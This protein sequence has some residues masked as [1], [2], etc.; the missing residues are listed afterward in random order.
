MNWWQLIACLLRHKWQTCFCARCGRTR[1]QDH[2][3]HR[4][5]GCVCTVCRS[6]MHQAKAGVCLRCGARIVERVPSFGLS[7]YDG[8]STAHRSL[9]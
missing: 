1:S 5:Q 7:P 9:S 6:T 3:A 8:A 4:W 2:P